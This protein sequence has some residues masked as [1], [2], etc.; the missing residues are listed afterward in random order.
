MTSDA[1]DASEASEGGSGDTVA[2]T[3]IAP[4][5]PPTTGAPGDVALAADFGDSSWE[6]TH[7]ELN[8]L[9]IPTQE[10]EAFVN[11][12]FRGVTPP[13]FAL[14]VL[15]ENL[16]SQAVQAELA[17]AG[18]EVTDADITASEESLV[19]QVEGLLVTAADPA[20]EAQA[21]YDSTPYLAFLVRYQA[22]QDALT[23]ILAANA[24]PTDGLPCVRHILVDTEPEALDIQTRLAAGEDFGELAIELSTGPSGEVGGELGCGP[25][26]QWVPP[27]AE[28]VD[29]AEIGEF[30]GPVQ[31]DFGWHIIVVDRT[32]VDGRAIASELLQERVSTAAITLDEN[33][34]TWD[35]TRLAIEP[36][37]A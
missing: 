7:G 19:G 29:A 24:D 34:G 26:S 12:V 4:P 28:A 2:P 8:D 14:T 15:T 5:S 10:N 30:V 17:A 37:G 22:A 18:G 1:S 27:F 16:F 6:I 33:L 21:L 36:A 32:E 31:T 3:S 35:P 13:D 20:A 11:L 23:E 25:S 9:V